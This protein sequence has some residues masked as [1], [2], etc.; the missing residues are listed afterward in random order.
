MRL[1]I[2][3]DIH[4]NAAALREAIAATDRAGYDRR[5]FI[6]DLLTYG[7]EIEATLDLMLEAT[8]RNDTVLLRGNHDVLYDRLLDGKTDVP[9]NWVGAHMR[10]TLPQIPAD[11]WRALPFRDEIV[12]GG[13]ICAHANPFGRHDWTYL[14]TPQDHAQ[15]AAALAF[16][17]LR[18][19]VFGHT[20]RAKVYSTRQPV[21]FLEAGQAPRTHC[22][23]IVVL[24]AG[25]IGQPRASAPREVILWLDAAQDG[26]THAFVPLAYDVA[27]HTGAI[28]RSDL[29]MQ[30]KARCLDYHAG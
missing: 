1:A 3:G 23:G 30:V 6:G 7:V 15:A 20:H 28:R 19:G 10:W 27:A 26:F 4:G 12:T 9:D 5:V 22:S 14:N 16:R 8:A 25:S 17:G 29:P 13:L 21:G 18:A 11:R 2:I 24:N